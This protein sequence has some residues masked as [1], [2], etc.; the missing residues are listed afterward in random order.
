MANN[1]TGKELEDHQK[2]CKKLSTSPCRGCPSKV[3]WA[4][5]KASGKLIPLDAK[6]LVYKI[7]SYPDN[8]HRM[9]TPIEVVRV[10][11]AFVTHFAT[12]KKPEQF[13]SSKKAGSK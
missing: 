3:L 12:C 2:L 10:K 9:D 11:D 8:P 4:R 7:V 1:E 6:A 5:N 13:S